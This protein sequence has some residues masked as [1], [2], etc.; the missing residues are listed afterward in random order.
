VTVPELIVEVL[1]ALRNQLYSDRTVGE[2][3]RDERALKGAISRYG[4]VCE[5]RGWHFDVPFLLREIMG[6]VM[7]VK[8][9]QISG[10]LPVYLQQAIDTHVREH[11]EELNAQAKAIR[12]LAE[13][14]ARQMRVAPDRPPMPSAVELLA[15]LH[16]DIK[17]ASKAH[18][19]KPKAKPTAKVDQGEMF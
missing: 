11:A 4:Y 13:K 8:R 2:Y 18:R 1:A 6:V 7:V 9:Q 12:T 10:Y 16:R 3:F 5:Q 19:P 14:N 15:L 17:Q